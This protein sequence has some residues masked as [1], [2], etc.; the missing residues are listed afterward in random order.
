M[1]KGKGFPGHGV[2]PSAEARTTS[3]K[4]TG[5]PQQGASAVRYSGGYGSLNKASDNKK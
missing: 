3:K 4:G 5:K 2:K 1:G